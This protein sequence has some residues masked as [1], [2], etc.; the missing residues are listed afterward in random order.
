MFYFFK[1]GTDP[2]EFAPDNIHYIEK[3]DGKWSD[4]VKVYGVQYTQIAHMH[5][6]VTLQS[7]NSS[8]IN[9]HHE[10]VGQPGEVIWQV[11]HAGSN[12]Y[13][14]SYIGK[15]YQFELPADINLHF[16][17]SGDTDGTSW[18][19]V[20]LEQEIIYNGGISEEGFQT[21]N[22]SNLIHIFI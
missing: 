1:A 3:I 14:T 4:P 19:P 18:K 22:V 7:S 11:Q 16:N 6:L 17:K 10:K 5:H 9:E 8:A 20:N 21:M 15:T 13:T 12:L 2:L